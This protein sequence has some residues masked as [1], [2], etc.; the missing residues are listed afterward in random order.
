MKKNITINLFGQLYHIDEDAYELLRSY[1]DNMRRYFSSKEGGE[2]I[3]DDIEHRIA[4]LIAE[5]KANGTEAITIEHIKDIIRRI[6]NPEEMDDGESSENASDSAKEEASSQEAAPVR[7][8]LFRDPDNSVIGGVVSGLCKYLGGNDPLPWRIIFALLGFVTGSSIC[9]VYLFLWAIIPVACT[10]ED[11]LRMRGQTV[12]T[13]SLNE[14]FLRNNDKGND[15]CPENCKTGGCLNG[16]LSVIGFLFKAALIAIGGVFIVMMISVLI[17][18]V[19]ATIIGIPSLALMCGFDAELGNVLAEIPQLNIILWILAIASIVVIS[20]P[21]YVLLRRILHPRCESSSI[22]KRV[23]IVVSWLVAITATIAMV[24]LLIYKLD[25]ASDIYSDMKYC[26]NGMI[27]RGI[28]WSKLDEGMWTL[29]SF[30]NCNEF[31]DCE[32][33]NLVT[34]IKGH[35]SFLFTNDY[36]RGSM[37]S[38]IERNITEDAGKYKLCAITATG[39]EG[40][41][42]YTQTEQDSLPTFTPIPLSSDSLSYIKN[43]TWEK[44]QDLAYFKDKVKDEAEWENVRHR[45]KKMDWTYMEIPIE[46]HGGIIKYGITNDHQFTQQPWNGKWYRVYD[47]ALIKEDAIN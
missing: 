31:I 21:I 7:K 17:P 30:N 28:G 9:I 33:K 35:N 6:G 26:R 32:V 23:V 47:I 1:E 40:C 11:R 44:A 43:L 37:R 41:F 45:S 4:E 24:C 18:L 25:K 34:G 10:P 12:N 20:I 8:K 38:R 29:Q 3:A 13:Q 42:I 27:V 19:V 39:G 16:I 14:E 2:E 15:S 5:Q 36:D 22:G 46:H